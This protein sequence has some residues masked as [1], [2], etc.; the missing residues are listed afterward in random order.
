MV[1]GHVIMY[2]GWSSP[3]RGLPFPMRVIL[4]YVRKLEYE[5]ASVETFTFCH[6]FMDCELD[7]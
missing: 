5:P 7:M 4:G 6:A 3:P 2:V 1:C